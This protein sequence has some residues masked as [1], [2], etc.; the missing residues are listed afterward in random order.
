MISWFEWPGNDRDFLN[1]II[2]AAFW[3]LCLWPYWKHFELEITG[4]PGTKCVYLTDLDKQF[5][6]P[7]E[8]ETDASTTSVEGVCLNSILFRSHTA[9]LIG[10]FIMTVSFYIW[11]YRRQRENLARR[12]SF[13]EVFGLPENE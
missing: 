1:C 10:V 8:V 9:N 2:L 3:E 6:N 5:M 11:Q 4:T 12:P 7:N 13:R